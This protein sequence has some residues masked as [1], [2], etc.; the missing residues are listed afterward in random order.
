M[1]RRKKRR[2]VANPPVYTDFKPAGIRARGLQRIVLTLDEYEAIR[3]ADSMEL[4]HAA[5]AG[6]MKISRSTFSRLI[7]S[8]R[9]KIADFLTSG[10]LLSIRG[11]RVHFRRNIIRCGD[12]GMVFG[13]ELASSPSRCRSCGSGNLIDL[14]GGFGHGRCCIQGDG[15]E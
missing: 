2:I 1:P 5:A 8:A 12:C 14:A 3:L 15:S 4:S 9:G 11:G 13:A 7:E 10:K 6:K